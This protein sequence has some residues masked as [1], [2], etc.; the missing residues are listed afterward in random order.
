MQ[1]SAPEFA[2]GG[3]TCDAQLSALVPELGRS[4]FVSGI[5]GDRNWNRLKP[6]KIPRLARS[7]PTWTGLGEFRLRVGFAHV[8]IPAFGSMSVLH[9]RAIAR[10]PEMSPWTLGNTYDRPIPR[11][12]LEE[13]GIPREWFGQ[14]KQGSFTT[15]GITRETPSRFPSFEEF[16]AHH[17][18]RG[19]RALRAEARYGVRNARR[20][21]TRAAERYSLPQI[22]PR[23]TQWDVS[24]PGR[25]S[26]VVQWGC[27]IVQERYRAA[28]ALPRDA[29]ERTPAARTNVVHARR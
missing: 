7:D 26:L 15:L 16:H 17:Q 11:R 12:L 27:A 18:L 28:L 21:W 23:L 5:F 10:S 9:M 24:V 14:V 22:V 20:L 13:A 4:M 6:D 29:A 2:C 8:P 25:P 3:D 19:V 1:R